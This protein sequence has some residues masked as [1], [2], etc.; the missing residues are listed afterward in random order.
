MFEHILVCLKVQKRN[1]YG[2]RKHGRNLGKKETGKETKIEQL[3]D[4][5]DSKYFNV[6]NKS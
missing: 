5:N 3:F 6:L 2:I 4:R 1:S